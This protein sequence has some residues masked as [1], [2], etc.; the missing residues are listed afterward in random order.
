[1]LSLFAPRY[2]NEARLIVKN[3]R[4]LL[5]YK[6]DLL[7]A[8]SAEDFEGN[9]R[10]LDAA[11]RGRDRE[12][13]DAAA[14]ALDAQWSALMPPVQDAGWR[15]NCE[16]FL[17]AIV[18]AIAVRTFFLQPFTIPTGS[19]QPTLNGIIGWK[20]EPAEPAP[21]FLTQ[22]W[23]FVVR[24]R[25]YIDVRAKSDEQIL[26][27]RERKFLF[28][29]TFTDLR[30]ASGQGYTVYAPGDTLRRDFGVMPGMRYRAGEAIAH[31]F[32]DAGDHVFVDKASYNFHRPERGDVF[33]FKTT[34]IVYIERQLE[35]QNIEGSQYYIKRLAG[36]P[37]DELRV[38]PPNL[39]VNGERARGFGFERVMAAR[40]GYR[41]Y[42][43]GPDFGYLSMPDSVF[44][45]PE[46]RYFAMG[47]NSYNSSDSRFWG[48]VPQEN[49]A[50]RGMF[51]YWPFGA[52][53]GL[54]R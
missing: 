19:M 51:V 1:M 48:T 23:D 38:D 49:I 53:W 46:G 40:D 37:G 20:T 12:K 2:V 15:E 27:M 29:F 11:A 39:F 14:K 42:G 50:G 24:G 17:V 25:N 6:R 21:N 28:F 7:P 13:I 5:H 18:I 32:V 3:A 26:A 45:I 35:M 47:D 34:D 44:P 22:V 4:K 16:V 36:L 10:R 8:A 9:I 54:I 33:V 41:G 52:H 30:G 31:G 43:P